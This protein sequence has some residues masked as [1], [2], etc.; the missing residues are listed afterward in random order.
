M[1]QVAG[2]ESPHIVRFVLDTCDLGPSPKVLSLRHFT[3]FYIMSRYIKIYQD[4]SGHVKIPIRSNKLK[5]LDVFLQRI[6]LPLFRL[7]GDRLFAGAAP[8]VIE[9]LLWVA[10]HERNGIE[11][12]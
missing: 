10:H 6:G 4:M 1:Q 9:G 12:T 3:Y 2:L 5:V 8:V 7:E 11:Q